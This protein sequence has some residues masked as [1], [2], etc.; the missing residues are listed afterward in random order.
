MSAHSS[1]AAAGGTVRPILMRRL[2]PRCRRSA[3]M[4]CL[5]ARVGTGRIR[6]PRRDAH[7]L[8]AASSG[9]GRSRRARP[10]EQSG[11]RGVGF[12]EL[13][14][15]PTAAVP[16]PVE[17]AQLVLGGVDDVTGNRETKIE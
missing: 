7:V 4:V 6:I 13:N 5:P 11:R 10:V 9:R 12:V 15:P 1:G 16:E 2:P 3:T 8:G 17:S 14:V